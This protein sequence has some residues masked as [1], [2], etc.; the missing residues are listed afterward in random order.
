MYFVTIYYR[1]RD[2]DAI[3]TI[4]ERFGFE[5]AMTINGTWPVMVR[6]EDWQLLC[7]CEK[8]GFIDIRLLVNQNKMK[9]SELFINTISD[10]LKSECEKD[11]HFAAKMAAH[12]EKTP[13][14]VCNYI[15]AEVSKSGRCGFDDAEIYGMARHFIDEKELQDP[16]SD[17]NNVSMV[18]VNT[19]ADLSEEDEA[20]IREEAV[21]RQQQVLEEKRKADEV[22]KAKQEKEREERRIAKLREKREKENAMQ[23]DLFG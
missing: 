9:A 3:R 20:K 15:M 21:R 18:V 22:K 12:P 17:A 23:L 1:S 2:M 5:Q 4:R 6:H 7:E 11:K 16:G 8:R 19:S 13:E 10:F 14:A